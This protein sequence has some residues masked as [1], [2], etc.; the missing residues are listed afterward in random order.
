MTISQEKLYKATFYAYFLLLPVIAILEKNV[1]GANLLF[2]T[3]FLLLL[4]AGV[5]RLSDE[6]SIPVYFRLLFVLSVTVLAT[7][8][9]VV[10]SQYESYTEI[11]HVEGAKFSLRIALIGLLTI[12]AY[13]LARYD[14]ITASDYVVVAS[15]LV[16]AMLLGQVTS[17]GG[18]TRVQGDGNEFALGGATGHVAITAVILLSVLPILL[19]Q[20]VNRRLAT[21]LLIIAVIAIFVTFRRSAWIVASVLLAM[22]LVLVVLNPSR[23]LLNSL[24]AFVV[25]AIGLATATVVLSLNDNVA[26]SV[27]SRLS[28]LNVFS[29][30]TGAGRSIFWNILWNHV[31]NQSVDKTLFGNGVGF[32]QQLLERKFGLAIG[33]HNDWFDIFLSFGIVPILILF[34]FF[35]STLTTI[36]SAA[37]PTRLL[38]AYSVT[39]L[40]ILSVTT[41]GMFDTYTGFLH[42]TIGLAFANSIRQEQLTYG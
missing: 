12:F 16:L 10:L 3:I 32:I 26:D 37:M 25:I 22:H 2:N 23:G 36:I 15:Y 6:S 34:F 4:A 33:A 7:H 38:L 24:R 20:S 30:G 8:V 5:Y 17:A 29:G 9:I 13:K 21:V 27:H 39:T 19:V 11:S 31:S 42:A 28:D 18:D 35:L 1:G 40:A 14:V 41:G